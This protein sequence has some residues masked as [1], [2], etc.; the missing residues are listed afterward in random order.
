MF[1]YVDSIPQALRAM[2]RIA[3]RHCPGLVTE[4]P[5]DLVEVDPPLHESRRERVPHV[6]KAEV[7]NACPI[8]C[9]TKLPNQEAY[10]A[11]VLL[12]D[13]TSVNQKLVRDGWCRWYRKYAPDDS[14]L[15]ALETEAREANRGRWID[16]RP[17]PPWEWRKRA[18]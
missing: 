10:L 18:K 14:V 3:L 7:G 1:Q 11:D 9:F 4:Q 8:S 16:P 15:E 2:V 12:S 13:D 6:V 5:L 17:I